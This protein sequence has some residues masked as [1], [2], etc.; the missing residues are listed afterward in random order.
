[1]GGWASSHFIKRGWSV[2]RARK[3]T[4]FCAALCAVPLLFV[5][6]VGSP[7]VVVLIIG[8]GTA[9]HQAFSSN[10]F[11]MI[12]DLYPRRAVATVA[13]MGGMAG[14]AGGILIAQVT[15]WTLELTGSYLPILIYAGIAYLLAFTV[16]H[17]LVPKMEPAP[18]G[19]SA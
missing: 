6:Q 9:G 2:N 18:I 4:L 7:L 1:M 15:G 19:A 17:L 13:G 14:A 3:T 5:L 11:T 12:S 8:L 10:I 16:I